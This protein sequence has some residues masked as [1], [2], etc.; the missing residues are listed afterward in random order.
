MYVMYVDQT[1][2]SRHVYPSNMF[3]LH[4]NPQK[5]LKCCALDSL[6]SRMR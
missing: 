1:P 5:L 6:L 4:E 2:S 3:S